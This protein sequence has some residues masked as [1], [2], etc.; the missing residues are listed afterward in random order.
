MRG[1]PV[2][3]CCS[4]AAGTGDVDGPDADADAG[5]D[6]TAALEADGNAAAPEAGGKVEASPAGAEAEEA[7]EDFMIDSLAIFSTYL[8]QR[9]RACLPGWEG[10]TNLLD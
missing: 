2:S 4:A 5:D 3:G 7:S 9:A 10:W 1:D 8:M 6:N